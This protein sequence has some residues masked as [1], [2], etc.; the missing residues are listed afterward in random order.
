MDD[1]DDVDGL[2]YHL[3]CKEKVIEALKKELAQKT[4]QVAWMHAD[5]KQ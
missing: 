4:H 1:I 3:Q 5:S 2:R